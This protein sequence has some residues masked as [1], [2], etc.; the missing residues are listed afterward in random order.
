MEREG[1]RPRPVDE[2]VF[3]SNL[4]WRE[5]GG[6]IKFGTRQLDGASKV[7]DP[8]FVNP[9]KGDFRLKPAS[10]AKEIGFQQIDLTTVGPR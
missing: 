9:A 1:Y 2:L 5:G 6:E 3:R 10:P 7:A 8:L 4:Y